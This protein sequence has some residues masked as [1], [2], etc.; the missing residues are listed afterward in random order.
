LSKNELAKVLLSAGTK[1]NYGLP[2]GSQATK[3]QIGDFWHSLRLRE[4]ALAH[5]CALGREAAWRQ[6]LADYR[7]PLTRAA[8]GITGSHS[9]GTELADSLYSELFGL[10]ERGG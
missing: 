3:T 1:S 6:F 2:C 9:L 4:L 8:I 7:A 10:S 5:A